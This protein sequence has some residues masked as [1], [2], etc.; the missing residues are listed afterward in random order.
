MPSPRYRVASPP[1]EKPLLL[2]DGEC[3]FCRL[4]ADRWRERYGDRVD[5][6]TAQSQAGHF[7]EIPAAA[8]DLAIQL[9]EPNGDVHSGAAAALRT[10]RHG[11]GR[12]DPFIRAY[13][14]VAL[15]AVLADAVYGFVARHRPLLSRLT[16]LLAG[17]NLHPP[18]F[19]VAA[20][21][22]LR[23]L[24]AIYF[25]AFGSFWWQLGGLIGP[26]G[27]LPAQPYLDAFAS[28]FGILRFWYLPT[29][30]WLFG[31]GVFLHVLCGGG[32]IL[33]G[34]AF[35]RKAEPWC[36]ALLWLFYLSLCDVGQVFLGYQWD[37]LL[38][39]T[40]L[41]AVFFAPWHRTRAR[42]EPPRVARALLWWLLFRLM[43]M[44]GFVKLAGGDPTWRDLTALAHHYETQ[45]LPTWLAWHAHHLPLWFQAFSCGAMFAI[46]LIAPF[47]LF[48]PRRL[49]LAAALG[50]I[51]LQVL[52]ALTGNYTF[53]NYLTILLCLL[54]LDDA[55]WSRWFGIAPQSRADADADRRGRT[56]FPAWLHAPVFV[57]FL[58]A[59]LVITLPPLLRIGRWPGWYAALYRSIAVTRSVNSY[60]LF[61]VMT[62]SRPEIV[63]EGSADGREWK[64]YEFKWKP[65][66]PSRRP[67][68]IAPYQP[69]LD[70]QMWFAALAYPQFE[71]WM[72]PFLRRLAANEPAVT[73]LLRTNPFAGEPPRYLR[74]IL[75]DYQF[76]TA[77]E[78][79]RTGHWWKRTATAYYLQPTAVR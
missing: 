32:L 42:V 9:V 74:A 15:F 7:P 31:G 49:R 1:A 58:A 4:W 52:I 44:S 76:T 54:F 16:R 51:L 78:R 40:G 64:A 59:S 68:F 56:G 63:I 50:L 23:G 20:D 65:G 61:T 46:E 29:L 39:E 26:H 33:A 67:G 27:I 21:V 60:G 13:E 11:R 35:R 10:R 36:F 62:T 34:L 66:D 47:L 53:F 5:F 57:A 79:A 24:A 30:C 2:W 3:G 37:A 28:Q 12:S 45:P 69:R 6:A 55:W 41:L 18:R 72:D 70:W 14:N 71:P 48:G 19:T 17:P 25:V 77:A 8:Y 38:L 43:F 22:F 75:Y 73:R